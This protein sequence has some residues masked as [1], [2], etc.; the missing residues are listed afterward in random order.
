MAGMLCGA[1]LCA[2]CVFGIGGG[3][4]HE[5]PDVRIGFDQ[6]G[7]TVTLTTD[8]GDD[9]A[10][11]TRLEVNVEGQEPGAEKG[12]K[13]TYQITYP[14][15]NCQ[16][17]LEVMAYFRNGTRFS[18]Y[19]GGYPVFQRY[20]RNNELCDYN[21]KHWKK[22]PPDIGVEL[23]GGNLT[24]T[25]HGGGFAPEVQSMFVQFDTGTQYPLGAFPAGSSATINNAPCRTGATGGQ[26]I[27]IAVFPD[28]YRQGVKYYSYACDPVSG[29]AHAY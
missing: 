12:S 20:V 10:D 4:D 21:Q 5:Y 19:T 14:V 16:I 23:R 24:I 13:S 9:L 15:G 28:G 11:V 27:V 6:K 22:D 1:M 8:G 18:S 3:H 17:S 25:N 29:V 7:D 2:G 26:A